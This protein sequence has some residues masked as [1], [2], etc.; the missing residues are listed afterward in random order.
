MASTKPQKT[1]QSLQSTPIAEK[2]QCKQRDTEK[3]DVL[4]DLSSASEEWMSAT[5]P[6]D[7]FVELMKVGKIPDPF[8]EMNENEVQWV[9]EVDWMYRTSFEWPQER[10]SN[11]SSARHVLC[12]DGLDTYASVY[13]N[14]KL[15]LQS[16]NMFAPYRVD[17]T[18]VLN[19]GRNTSG[20]LFESAFLKGKE[21]EKKY[22]EHPCWNGDTSRLYV[23]KAQYHYSWDWGPKLMT[24]GIWRRVYLESYQARISDV[25]LQ[26]DLA[27]D[28]KQAI[29]DV[30]IEVEDTDNYAR[31]AQ[32]TIADP[33]G[34]IVLDS[35]LVPVKKG[36][37]LGKLPVLHDPELWWPAGHGK[38]PLYTVTASI[39]QESYHNGGNAVVLDTKKQRIGIRDLQV[40]QHPLKGQDGTSFFFQVNGKGIFAGGSNWIPADNFLTRISS[41]RYRAWLE[42][43]VNGNQNTVRVWGGGIFEDDIFYNLCDELGLLLWQDFMFGCGAYPA[44]EEFQESVRLEAEANVRRLRNHACLAIFAG[45]NED[46]QVRESLNLWTEEQFPA[47][48][49]YE[50]LLPSIVGALSPKSQYWRGSPYTSSDRLTTDPTIGDLHQ[51]NIWGNQQQKYQ[52]YPEIGGRF[53]SEFGMES[54]PCVKTIASFTDATKAK[55]QSE[56]MMHHNKAEDNER[57]L[58]TYL[59]EN[60]RFSTHNLADYVYATQ[61]IQSEA[62][63][64]AYR[65]WIRRWQGPDREYCAGVLVWQINDCWPVSSWSI[66]DYYLRPKPAYY[67]IKRILHTTSVSISRMSVK[68]R[69]SVL[70]AWAVNLGDEAMDV[71]YVLEGF[72]LDGNRVLSKHGQL[73]L[74]ANR[75][76]EIVDL[77]VGVDLDMIRERNHEVV[78][79]IRLLKTGSGMNSGDDDYVVV[80]GCGNG[81]DDVEV[82]ARFAS[83]PEPFKYLDIPDPEIKLTQ[84][85]ETLT[86]SASKP[87][88][89]IW[90]EYEGADDELG[91]TMSDNMVDLMPGDEQIIHAPHCKGNV[92]IRWLGKDWT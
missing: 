26:V 14:G 1:E 69:S 67:T 5:V 78:Y 80:E 30:E 90:I 31:V 9:G 49:I 85:G 42:L 72:T 91:G 54:L 23:R 57:R 79:G 73:R 32:V 37:G 38:Q 10:S 46:Y 92:S 28:H 29:V 2:W 40:V 48:V 88:K 20:I 3:T 63:S 6:S 39:L 51:W 24:C 89:G 61:F 68:D 65:G 44:H 84:R 34:Q 75:S 7:I 59:I 52:Y 70:E 83:W 19:E 64:S 21:E 35:H 62:L 22:G 86:L 53:V 15:I 66:V 13:L 25:H 77:T 50:E 71:E 74:E 8:L 82:L 11:S 18:H 60:I 81:D 36:I 16:S 41:D 47:R 76:Q 17:V 55:P 4:C 45:N 12:F 87:A 27:T 58:G 56:V 43:M 33:Q